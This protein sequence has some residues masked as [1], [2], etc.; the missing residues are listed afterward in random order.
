M[1][2]LPC[3]LDVQLKSGGFSSNFTANAT[4]NFI[5]YDL[6]SGKYDLTVKSEEK[7]GAKSNKLSIEL[8]NKQVKGIFV[9]PLPENNFK[10]H[11]GHIKEDPAK[12]AS[13][14]P[15]VRAVLDVNSAD[16][17][18]LSFVKPNTCEM[19]ELVSSVHQVLLLLL[20]LLAS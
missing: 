1:N 14:F 19:K 17:P 20:N 12:L 10:L 16:Y 4:L 5:A 6:D 7:C 2:T 13:S 18:I 3:H 8:L 9:F 11:D 15:K